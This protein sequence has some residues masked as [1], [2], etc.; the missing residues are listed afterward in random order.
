MATT[1]GRD[2]LSRY[3]IVST[4]RSWGGRIAACL[5]RF[6]PHL[7]EGNMRS[8]LLSLVGMW[9]ICE[10]IQVDLDSTGMI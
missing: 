1:S 4:F 8:Q 9:K 3:L 7:I 6:L 5:I 10:G 2:N